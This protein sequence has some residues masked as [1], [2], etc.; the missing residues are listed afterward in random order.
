M[1]SVK[2]LFRILAIIPKCGY[3]DLFLSNQYWSIVLLCRAAVC[4]QTI[5]FEPL[6][7]ALVQG[8]LLNDTTI[9]DIGIAQSKHGDLLLG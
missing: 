6:K 3:A 1:Q 8:L 5:F 7:F 9:L 4:V 2:Q